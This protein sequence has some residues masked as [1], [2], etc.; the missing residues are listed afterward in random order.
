MNSQAES[1][2]ACWAGVT[3]T[4]PGAKRLLGLPPLLD[5][6]PLLG[7]HGRVLA[8]RAQQVDQVQR[9]RERDEEARRRGEGDQADGGESFLGGRAPAKEYR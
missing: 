2:S 7:H 4:L 8:A 1:I 5:L 6:P 9:D 3:A